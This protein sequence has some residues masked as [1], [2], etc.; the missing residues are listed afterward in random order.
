M[1]PA[2]RVLCPGDMQFTFKGHFL[3]LGCLNLSHLAFH[4]SAASVPEVLGS[5]FKLLLIVDFLVMRAGGLA[6]AA[7][8]QG[9]RGVNLG[10]A[11]KGPG[12]LCRR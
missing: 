11:A 7:K 9:W 6:G 2:S 8:Q 1:H 5:R 3:L 10:E 4:V 12:C